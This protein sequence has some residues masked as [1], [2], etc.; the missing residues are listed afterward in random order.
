MFDKLTAKISLHLVL[1]NIVKWIIQDK[2]F[3]VPNKVSENDMPKSETNCEEKD[4][5]A[6]R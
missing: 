2:I 4:D 6:V 3:I 5:N 1:V